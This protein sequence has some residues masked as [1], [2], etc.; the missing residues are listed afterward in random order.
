M[1]VNSRILVFVIVKRTRAS[2]HVSCAIEAIK[3]L[4]LLLSYSLSPVPCY[5]EWHQGQADRDVCSANCK[6]PKQCEVQSKVLDRQGKSNST[7]GFER[8][9]EDGFVKEN[10]LSVVENLEE[11]LIIKYI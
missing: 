11:D 4:L 6:S 10:F 5:V 9:G 7:S 1:I 2:S 3:L 8:H